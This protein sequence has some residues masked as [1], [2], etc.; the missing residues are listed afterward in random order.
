VL[1]RG[2]GGN[3]RLENQGKT[4]PKRCADSLGSSLTAD[5]G[6]FTFTFDRFQ[7]GAVARE[8]S[9]EHMPSAVRRCKPAPPVVTEEEHA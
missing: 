5:S 3:R 1:G 8:P 2:G 4:S 6:R 9:N 7:T